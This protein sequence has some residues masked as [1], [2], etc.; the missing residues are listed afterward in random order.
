MHRQNRIKQID[1]AK[2]AK[3]QGRT[4]DGQGLY[5]EVRRP[6]DASWSLR[7]VLNHRQRYLGLGPWPLIGLAEARHKATEARKLILAGLDPV[8]EKHRARAEA[9]KVMTF[10]QVAVE[11]L[12]N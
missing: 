10:Q 8:A 2:L 6:G 12:A 11:F 7:Y 4:N 1:L 5:F 3:R 9:L